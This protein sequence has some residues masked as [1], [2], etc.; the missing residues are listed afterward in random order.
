MKTR[1]AWIVGI[2][3][4][5]V[6]GLQAKKITVP[7]DEPTIQAGI[8]KAEPGDTVAVLN[9]I[10]NESLVLRDGISLIGE[11]FNKTVIR[12]FQKACDNLWK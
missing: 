3:L 4:F 12:K 8:E 6:T 1:Q 5:A 7:K 10:Y 9:G 11:T 2:L